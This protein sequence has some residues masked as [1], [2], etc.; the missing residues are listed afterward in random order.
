VVKNSLIAVA[1]FERAI[2]GSW[3]AGE[4]ANRERACLN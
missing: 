1:H 3:P 2:Y 4:S